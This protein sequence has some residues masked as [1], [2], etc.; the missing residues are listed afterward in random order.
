MEVFWFLHP[1]FVFHETQAHT[2]LRE[3]ESALLQANCRVIRITPESP[4]LY[5]GAIVHVFSAIDPETAWV[6]KQTGAKVIVTPA[7]ARKKTEE[8]NASH[9]HS[10]IR[11][12]LRRLWQ[13]RWEPID[14]DYYLKATDH[15][16]LCD[17]SWK[18]A[19]IRAGVS[20]QRI[21]LGAQGT[22]LAIASQ[23]G[24]VYERLAR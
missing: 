17:P 19:L 10:G 15:Y 12:L 20:D 11:K 8:N 16:W 21:E 24:L 1:D 5:P 2:Q 9:S 7:L 14:A 18:P 6:L 3:V 23:W 4:T 13:R 22:A